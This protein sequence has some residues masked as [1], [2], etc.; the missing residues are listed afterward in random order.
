VHKPF[1]SNYNPLY[2]GGTRASDDV[3]INNINEHQ[4]V[5]TQMRREDNEDFQEVVNGLEDDQE[6]VFLNGN[7]YNYQIDDKYLL[8]Q[9]KLN[10][11]LFADNPIEVGQVY[12][13]ATATVGHACWKDYVELYDLCVRTGNSQTE[14]DLVIEKISKMNARRGVGLHMPK[15]FK[16]IQTAIEKSINLDY[17]IRSVD[18]LL[19]SDFM[20][21]MILTLE[22]MHDM[23]MNDIYVDSTMRIA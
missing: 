2:Y 21:M 20:L 18:V 19:N 7:K 13:N 23:A 10:S 6:D 11:T 17:S 5:A 12:D 8:F 9:R 15:T 3:T 14:C 22:R 4:H 1:Q 16:A